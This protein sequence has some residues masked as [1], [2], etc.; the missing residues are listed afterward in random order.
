MN[1]IQTFMLLS[2]FYVKFLFVSITYCG[3]VIF[4]LVPLIHNSED[5]S[6]ALH[7]L[8]LVVTLSFIRRFHHLADRQG[9]RSKEAIFNAVR[10][11]TSR[12][13]HLLA[14]V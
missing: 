7:T 14:Q 10:G 13:H 2:E 1:F 11:R 6:G 8:L 12:H 4:C 3:F 5:L 9:H